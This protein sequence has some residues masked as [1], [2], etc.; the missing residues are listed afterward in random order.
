MYISTESN[1]WGY[2]IPIYLSDSSTSKEIRNLI[3]VKISETI[4]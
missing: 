4:I 3:K 1:E 2:K